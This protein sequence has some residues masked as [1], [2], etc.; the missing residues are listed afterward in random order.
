MAKLKEAL[1]EFGRKF[2]VFMIILIVGIVMSRFMAIEFYEVFLDKMVW[3]AIGFFMGNGMT[4]IAD[5][6][7]R[8]KR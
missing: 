4:H 5:S 3:I 2:I 6:I 8:G 7:N 1:L